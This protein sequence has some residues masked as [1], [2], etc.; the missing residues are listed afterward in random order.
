MLTIEFEG[1]VKKAQKEVSRVGDGTEEI[2][3]KL[4][5]NADAGDYIDDFM[6]S[7]AP[8]F[9]GK[10]DKKKKDMAIAAYLDAKDKKEEVEL[11]ELKEPFVVV[12]TVDK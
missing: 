1:D 2:D 5:K 12:D 7:D 10:S 9:K 11:D 8:Q 3:E 4:G 6:K